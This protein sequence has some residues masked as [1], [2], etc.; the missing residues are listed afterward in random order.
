MGANIDA[1]DLTRQ[2]KAHSLSK[3]SRPSMMQAI[4]AGKQT[5]IDALNGMFVAEGVAAG[6][7][8]PYNESVVA[9]T[10]GVERTAITR[11]TQP[12]SAHQA[13]Y[14]E[15]EEQEISA[16][17]AGNSPML[18]GRSNDYSLPESKL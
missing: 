1:E 3:F 16:G 15:W 4:E 17:T 10:K 13:F 12:D 14:D 6:L 7:P 9:F 11:R 8:M 2:I 5:E 18:S